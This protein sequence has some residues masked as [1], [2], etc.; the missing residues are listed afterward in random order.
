LAVESSTPTV[1]TNGRPFRFRI[2]VRRERRGLFAL[3]RTARMA[4]PIKETAVPAN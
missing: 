3:V 1:R 4:P 2:F